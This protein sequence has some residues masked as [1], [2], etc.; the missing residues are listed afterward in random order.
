MVAGGA[1]LA[2]PLKLTMGVSADVLLAQAQ[3]HTWLGIRWPASLVFS[4]TLEAALGVA[5]EAFALLVGLVE[6]GL[7]ITSGSAPT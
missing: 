2:E 3:L 6:P 7:S 4:A 5:Q 1:P